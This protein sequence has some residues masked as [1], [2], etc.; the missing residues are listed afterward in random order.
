MKDFEQLANTL[1]FSAHVLP[2]AELPFDENFRDFCAENVCGNYGICYSCP[3]D[4]GTYETLRDSV[5][6][7]KYALVL[8]TMPHVNNVFDREEIYNLRKSHNNAEMQLLAEIKKHCATA[9]MI[10]ASTCTLC[11]PC[12][13]QLGKPCAHPDIRF[14][15]LSAYCIDVRKTA[16]QCQIE[17]NYNN[18]TAQMPFFGMIIFD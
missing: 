6:A 17:F 15:C 13:K 16:S 12:Q 2:T 8:Q 3:P 10:G 9:F 5:L 14:Y 18:K 11:R 7:H 1:G 4:C